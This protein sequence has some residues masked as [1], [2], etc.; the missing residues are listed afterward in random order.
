MLYRK[1]SEEFYLCE[2]DIPRKTLLFHG[3]YGYYVASGYDEDYKK[4]KEYA[5]PVNKFK[6]E[7]LTS[8]SLDES[9]PKQDDRQM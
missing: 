5:L 3:G 6:A 7:F 4:A 2:F 9:K 8:F 1:N